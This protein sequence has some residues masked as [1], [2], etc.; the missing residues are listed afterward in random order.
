[1][2][3]ASLKAQW[4]NE[5]NKATAHAS[6]A[7]TVFNPWCAWRIGSFK[8]PNKHR[9][10]LQGPVAEQGDD[11]RPTDTLQI[12][13]I[14]CERYRSWHRRGSIGV[15]WASSQSSHNRSVPSLVAE[16]FFSLGPSASFEKPG[17]FSKRSSLKALS[18]LHA[19]DLERLWT[20]YT[21]SR[22]PVPNLW[23]PL[24]VGLKTQGLMSH[25]ILCRDL[26]AF[27][28]AGEGSNAVKAL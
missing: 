14:E 15:T 24:V 19:G 9:A 18:G 12:T 10:P 4:A 8:L 17:S 7:R 22:D 16:V 25:S 6:A 13:S 3:F 1:M 26:N 11:P 27:D 5:R 2:T 28:E 23:I 21:L 20:H